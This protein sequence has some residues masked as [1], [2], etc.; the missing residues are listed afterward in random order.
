MD[1]K[2]NELR[3]KL[4]SVDA[5]IFR[6]FRERMETAE[7][8]GEAKRLAGLPTEDRERENAVI[9]TRTALL[10]ERFRV[11]GV[12]LARLLI[13]EY[14]NAFGPLCAY[15]AADRSASSCPSKP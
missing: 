15:S 13:E 9:A 10:P 8:I 12:A 7:E 1:E 6:L 5:E 4:D 14:E 11:G 3:K 2:L